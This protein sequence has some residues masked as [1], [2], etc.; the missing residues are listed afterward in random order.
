MLKNS[1][2][3]LI[4]GKRAIALAMALVL[5]P[6]C[7]LLM[8]MFVDHTMLATRASM[9]ERGRSQASHMAEAG[10]LLAYDAFRANNF[11][12]ATAV[13]TLSGGSF[14]LTGPAPGIFVAPACPYNMTFVSDG[15]GWRT[16]TW[17]PGQATGFPFADGMGKESLRYR[18]YFIDPPQ[19]TKWR[20]DSQANTG[21]YQQT[22]SQEGYIQNNAKCALYSAG[23]LDDLGRI[24]SITVN[25]TVH[26]N[27]NVYLFPKRLES[28]TSPL[29]LDVTYVNMPVWL[30]SIQA[31]FKGVSWL[32]KASPSSPIS[33]DIT[34][35]VEAGGKIIRS[36]DGHGENTGSPQL[37]FTNCYANINGVSLAGG[38]NL[39]AMDS[40]N[41]GWAN[42]VK[43]TPA[44]ALNVTDNAFGGHTSDS[45]DLRTTAPGGYY[46]TLAST[47][48]GL[49][50]GNASAGAPGVPGV[51]TNTIFNNA[52]CRNVT[53]FDVDVA[54]VTA[55]GNNALIYSLSPIRLQNADT[56]GANLTVV[57]PATIYTR[58]NFN[59]INPKAAALITTDRIYHLS[60]GFNDAD[61][62]NSGLVPF[63]TTAS[64]DLGLFGGVSLTSDLTKNFP[65]HASM[66]S[67]P[68]SLTI[69]A[70]L[71]DGVPVR[72]E[73]NWDPGLGYSSP[74]SYH[75]SY[76]TQAGRVS[77]WQSGLNC[78][79]CSD[80]LL[81]EFQQLNVDTTRPLP[82]SRV[83]LY[84]HV[85]RK[86]SNP[87]P[88]FPPVALI[89]RGSIMHLHCSNMD[90]SPSTSPLPWEQRPY[91]T[92]WLVRSYYVPAKRIFDS[93]PSLPP[94]SPSAPPV[95]VPVPLYAPNICVK[96]L[97]SVSGN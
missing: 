58:G 88:W 44:L 28:R 8:Y 10:L 68:S 62:R 70:D 57:S 60:E 36:C 19:N 74:S 42:F 5:M 67:T 84:G 16:W 30:P 23:D 7:M 6:I 97:W 86:V 72:Q 20:I 47:S 90:P 29:D 77:P 83:P 51:A 95:P 14:T 76:Y 41:T 96:T 43:S 45:F 54:A 52:E 13:G 82:D 11:S 17:V 73:L 56:L 33:V 9:Q 71:V 21:G 24:D 25:G 55:S 75:T 2:G 50:L 91:V 93:T 12:A 59:R 32:V 63:D 87:D 38:A 27:G 1:T 92:P 94:T 15:Q 31:K 46:N 37:S 64:G 81:E 39:M 65:P 78:A 89:R 4:F 80:G 85:L 40:N 49:V 22:Q 69:Q 26:A 66:T 61:P 34:G 48:G 3:Q 18:I 79:A 35:N 53:F